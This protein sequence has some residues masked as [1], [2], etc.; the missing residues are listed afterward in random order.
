[1][2]IALIHVSQETND[3]NPEPTTLRDFEAFGLFEGQEIVDRV[4]ALGQIGGHFQAIRDSGLSVE[5]VPIIRAHAVAGGRIDGAAR[6][7]FLDKIAAGLKA[8]GKI[9]GLALQLHGA[10]SAEGLDDV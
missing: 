6:R 2:R 8:A 7:F 1:M 5:T 3:F 4:G 9:D 10:S